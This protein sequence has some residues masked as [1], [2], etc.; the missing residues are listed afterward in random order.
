MYLIKKNNIITL[1]RGDYLEFPLCLT[2]GEFPDKEIYELE[3]SDVVFFGLTFP[4][5]PFE[6]A[7]LKKEYTKD[8][9]DENNNLI[10]KLLPEDTIRLLPGNYYYS[11]KILYHDEV[12]NI[13]K[14]DTIIDKT[15]F[16]LVD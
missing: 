11:V 12:D 1:T 13:S 16:I 15:K 7:I 10:I 4:H 14:I 6:K 3:D 2:V 9:L 5:Q 8:D